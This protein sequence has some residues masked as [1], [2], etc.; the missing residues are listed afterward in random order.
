M[1]LW[2]QEGLSG[3]WLRKVR[4]LPIAE[5]QLSPSGQERPLPSVADSKLQV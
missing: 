1:I 5:S 4:A 3:A 2:T